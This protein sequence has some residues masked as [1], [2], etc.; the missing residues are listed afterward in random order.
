MGTI[1]NICG[2]ESEAGRQL[3]GQIG[4]IVDFDAVAGRYGVVFPALRPATVIQVRVACG[5]G[6]W[7]ESEGEQ[8]L[9]SGTAREPRRCF[10]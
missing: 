5:G 1:V 9:I 2:L 10:F 8:V 3:N 4:R 7:G 6:G